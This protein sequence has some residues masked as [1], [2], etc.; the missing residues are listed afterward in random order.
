[1]RLLDELQELSTTKSS[2]SRRQILHKITDLF[3]MTSQQQE[4]SHRVAFDQI[5]DRLA[6]ELETSVR[7]EFADRLA[8]MDRPPQKVTYKFAVDE[9]T[10]ARPILQRSKILSDDFL[11]KVAK[12]QS[13]DHLLAICA[14][15]NINTRVTD[16]L[17]ERGNDKVLE[18][19]SANDGANFS[20]NGFEQL[21]A[22]AAKNNELN[23]ILFERAD[24]PADILQ[25]VKKRVSTKLK[26]ETRE[27]G[28]D[29]SDVEID[30]TIDAQSMK[31]EFNTAEE[32]ASMQ[33]IDFLHQRKQL[34]ERVILHYVKLEKV[35]ETIY[36][37]SKMTS[38][39]QEV[40]QHCVLQADLPA[41]AVLCKAN[42]FQRSTFASL[43]QLR[44]N[45]IDT[46]ASQIVD[47]IRRYESLDIENAQR[48]M[49]FLKVR[50]GAE[51]AAEKDAQNKNSEQLE[52][53][54]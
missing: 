32:K 18:N 24:T 31:I 5:M 38:L 9:I 2:E 4:E 40:V 3:V 29:I 47:A 30:S 26:A 21:A 19:V 42:N 46:D 23:S 53:S 1:M 12:T 44:E 11:V 10:V 39:E 48:V 36:S 7:A 25:E 35:P 13:Q 16:V 52:I 49:R 28:A 43:L 20:R 15:D 37:L 33:E 6:Y 50:K 17:V 22:K 51:E 45:V 14:R 27:Q 54:A 41:L 34:D 8:D